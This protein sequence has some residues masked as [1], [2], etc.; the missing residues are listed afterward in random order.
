M[1]GVADPRLGE[2]NCLCVVPKNGAAVTLEEF[3]DF[4]RDQVATYKLPE[5]LEILDELPFTP[6]GK[7]QRFVLQ[8]EI[9][10]RDNAAKQTPPSS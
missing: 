8:K 2:R 9:A 7:I 1:V 6:T 3:T 4:L 10:A 5:R